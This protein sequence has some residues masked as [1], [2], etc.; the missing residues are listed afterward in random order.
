MS[1]H[2]SHAGNKLAYYNKKKNTAVKSFTVETPIPGQVSSWVFFPVKTGS[3][4]IKN[5]SKIKI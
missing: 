4:K 3:S 5:G 1:S 2:I